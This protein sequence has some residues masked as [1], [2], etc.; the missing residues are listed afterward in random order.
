MRMTISIPDKV[1]R[2]FC[3]KVPRKYRSSIIARFMEAE[4]NR[5]DAKLKE[6]CLKAN[7]DK[8]LEREIEEW[9]SFDEVIE[10]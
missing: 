9:Q 5:R 6:A 2:K 3:K 10:E 7:Q 4:S 1:A 8:N